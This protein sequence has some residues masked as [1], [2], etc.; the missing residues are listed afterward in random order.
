MTEFA[1]KHPLGA[2]ASVSPIE[3]PSISWVYIFPTANFTFRFGTRTTTQ[4]FKD[5]E[6]NPLVALALSDGNTLETLQMR[7]QATAILEPDKVRDLLE[8]LRQT[9]AKER[10]HWMAS[11][12]KAARGAY[13][14]DVS[15]WLPPVSQMR[16]GSYVFFEI[17]P[18]WARF[19]RYDADW[20]E[21]KDFSEYEYVR[22]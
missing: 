22:K 20:K 8:T 5:I 19:R 9:F 11:E 21:G 17:V 14:M 3:E 13:H 4:K 6:K 7:G 10:Q 1:E 18:D 15:R 2:L 12:D 16:E